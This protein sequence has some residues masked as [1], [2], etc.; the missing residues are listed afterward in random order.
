MNQFKFHLQKNQIYNILTY[1]DNYAIGICNDFR[2]FQ[3]IRIFRLDFN[4][5]RAMGWIYKR[6]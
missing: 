2:I 3:K 6:L 5:E 1:A 4:G